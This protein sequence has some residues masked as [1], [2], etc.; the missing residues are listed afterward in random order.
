MLEGFVGGLIVAF[1]LSLFCVDEMII[2]VLQPFVK[3]VTLTGSHYYIM[4][5]LIGLI[6]G[7]L[8]K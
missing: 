8:G 2:E 6:G 5:G 7:A 4:F 1:I 3:T